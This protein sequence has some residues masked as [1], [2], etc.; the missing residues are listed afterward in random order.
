MERKID[1]Q[2]ERKAGLL[3]FF[4]VGIIVLGI[5]SI[6]A[7]SD[8]ISNTGDIIPSTPTNLIAT[9]GDEQ[10]A[11]SWDNVPGTTS[12]TIYWSTSTGVTKDNCEGEIPEAKNPCIHRDLT[13]DTIYYYVVTAE[14]SNGESDESTEVGAKPSYAPYLNKV[15]ATIPVNDGPYGT[16]VTPDGEYLYVTD[17]LGNSVSVI[18]TSDNTVI[19]TILVGNNPYGVA[20]TPD[21]EYVYVANTNSHTVSVIRTSDNTVTGTI[22]VGDNP[23]GVAI[24]PDGEYVYATNPS[25]DV[26]VD[27]IV[28]VI[29]TSNNTVT[30]TIPVG[31][32]PMAIVISPDGNYVYVANANGHT[33]SVIQTSENVVADTILINEEDGPPYYAF[34]N[35]LTITP[36]GNYLYVGHYEWTGDQF[37]KRISVIRTSD[38]SKIAEIS[39]RVCYPFSMAV[40][41]NGRY[42]YAAHPLDN[43]VSVIRTSDNTVVDT[44]SVGNGPMG[45]VI[46]PDGTEVYVANTHDHTVTIIGDDP[47]RSLIPPPPPS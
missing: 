7:C 3:Y 10:V 12:Y 21:G 14:N 34:P 46:N 13:N 27:S 15:T 25:Y 1:L 39:S 2:T 16:A 19:G 32:D 28:T 30:K 22:P 35:G 4:L 18:R 37:N 26:E 24:T 8:D 6:V 11:L 41:P 42:V 29:R 43:E 17:G 9:A 40:T 20:V 31:D 44:I 33:I 38:N 23:Y 45:V 36:D 5:M 47:P